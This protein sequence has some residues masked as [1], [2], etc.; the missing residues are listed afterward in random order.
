MTDPRPILNASAMAA[1]EAKAIAAGT[2][3][4]ELM[5]RA[6]SALAEAILRFAGPMPVLILAGPG[7]NGGDGYVAARHL[8][9]HGVAV[10][11]AASGEPKTAAAKAAR[12]QWD[13]EVE[14]LGEATAPAA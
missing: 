2:S 4:D 3:V 6:G 9:A 8:S 13:G 11:I 10:R 7:N 5:E 12:K 14:P 1:A